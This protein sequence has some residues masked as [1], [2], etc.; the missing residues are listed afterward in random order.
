MAQLDKAINATLVAHTG[1]TPI[2]RGELKFVQTPLA[3]QTWKPIPHSMLVDCIEETLNRNHLQIAK[4]EYAVQ[5]EGNKLFGVMT[6][7]SEFGG[8]A[9]ALG[10]RTSNDK[11]F[12]VQMIAGARVF[13]CDNL[14]FSGDVIMLRRK[15]TAGLN[16]REEVAGG[17]Q[18]AVAKFADVSTSVDRMKAIDLT[19]KD[20]A[21]KAKILD[22]AVKGVMPLRLIP[23]VYENYFEPKH[24]E[25]RPRNAWSLHNAFTEAFKELK[26][27][28]AMQ[29][30]VE[31]GRL[32]NV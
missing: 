21:A 32:F 27:N 2:G 28:I 12:P 1:A 9:L 14:A 20:V 24:E 10:L 25:F 17:I 5:S 3:T 15:H 19:G 26:P 29:S 13:V 7:S 22:A 23:S 16:I 31:L 18:R 6:L 8:Y 4:E 30:G 11:S